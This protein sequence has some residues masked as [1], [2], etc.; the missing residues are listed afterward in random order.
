V[1]DAKMLRRGLDSFS[2]ETRDDIEARAWSQIA[3][4]AQAFPRL[5]RSPFLDDWS[6]D[7][8]DALATAFAE[9]P[10]PALDVDGCCRVY[11]AR[12]FACRTMGIP[13]E[14]G[15]TVEGACEVQTSVPVVRLPAIFRE[16]E[17][18]LAEQEAR[19]LQNAKRDGEEVLIAYGFLPEHAWTA[20]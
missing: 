2:T 9:F 16:Q 4:V 8:Q 13:I 10:C 18:G 19:E 6:D 1:L 15:E 3:A 14:V 20:F 17:E 12:P 5:A 11:E 7:E